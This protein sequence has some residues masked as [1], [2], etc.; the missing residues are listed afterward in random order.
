[1]KAA[2]VIMAAGMGSRYGGSKQ[3]DGIGPDGEIL[4]EYSIYDAIRAGFTKVV[5]IIKPE[6]RE[7]VETLCGRRV[8]GMTAADGSPVEVCYAYQG[9]FQRPAFYSIP[10]ERTKPF[11][12]GHAV[13][14][15]AELRQRAV[16]RHQRRR[17]LRCGR[18]P[19]DLRGAWE[20]QG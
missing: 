20:A 5:F 15:C 9:L 8:A 1:M 3:V 7:L 11:G 12:T 13:L 18:L 19:C 17:L 2:L 4:M 14:L 6:M 10:T 16:Y